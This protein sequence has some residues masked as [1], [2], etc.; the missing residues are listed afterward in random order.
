MKIRIMSDLHL[1]FGPLELE[2][3]G[4]DV[5]VLAGD[6]NLGVSAQNWAVKMNW[7]LKVPVVMIAGN[8]E[9][10]NRCF[11]Y[12]LGLFQSANSK[13]VYFLER[14]SVDISGVRFLGTTL[15]TDYNLY[16]RYSE[17]KALARVSLN[18]HRLITYEGDMIFTP[19]HAGEEH[20]KAVEFLETTKGDVI[21]THH[22]PSVKSALPEFKN[23]PLTAA[24][25]SNL[26]EL[27][28]RS[29]AKLWIH[30]HMH[31]SVDYMIGQ[32]RV[33][34]NPRGY[35]GHEVNPD[36]DPNFVVEI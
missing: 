10:Y 24:Y 11:I 21:V 35:V 1:E 25:A 16:G 7:Q 8:H 18:D 4:E 14:E 22:A 2:P 31:N 9:Y 32:T 36:F 30:G 6:T 17:D 34:S 20:R 3:A 15:W 33:V 27:V 29:G 23:D 28:A 13:E 19:S 12:T 26:E 5:L